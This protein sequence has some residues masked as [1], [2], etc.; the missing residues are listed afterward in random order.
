MGLIKGTAIN[1]F[2]HTTDF[3]T[4]DLTI[5]NISNTFIWP[6]ASAEV[7]E[8]AEGAAEAAADDGAHHGDDL[9]QIWRCLISLI[10]N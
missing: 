3:E 7:V 2:M 10:I 6:Q 9:I 1:C 5:Q 4:K 8:R